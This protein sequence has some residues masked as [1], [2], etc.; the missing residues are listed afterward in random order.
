MELLGELE[1]EARMDCSIGLDWIGLDSKGGF[2]T[3]RRAGW[4]LRLDI[5]V[6]R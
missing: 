6:G 1:E 3:G 5:E 2:W 4:E